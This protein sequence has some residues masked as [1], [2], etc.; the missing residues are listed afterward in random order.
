MG[1]LDR[2]LDK[3][4]NTPLYLQMKQHFLDAYW[5][6]ELVPGEIL[7]SETELAEHFGVSKATVRQCMNSLSLEGFVDKRRNRGTVVLRKKVDFG[8]SDSIMGFHAKV[9]SMGM[10]PRTRLLHLSM[11][12]ASEEVAQ[13]LGIRQKERVIHL[14][15]LRYVNEE[16][17]LWIDSYL[18]Y[19]LLYFIL[20][21]DFENESLYDVMGERAATRVASVQRKVYAIAANA[22][23]AEIFSIGL[24]SAM[25][26][27]DNAAC[28]DNGQVLEASLTLSPGDRN[29]Y[30]FTIRR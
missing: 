21:H 22:E 18:P 2:T 24:N 26:V 30:T 23:M 8:F 4:T 3:N 27:T 11:E 29:E 1:F 15:R 10:E 16:P 19:D 17:M 25:L 5:G 28:A 13:R 6:N 20:G 14:V 9:R 7:P 12:E